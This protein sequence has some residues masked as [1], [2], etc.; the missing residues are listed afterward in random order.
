MAKDKPYWYKKALP[1]LHRIDATA[2]IAGVFLTMPFD[3]PTNY[4]PLSA[5]QIITYLQDIPALRDRLG[6]TPADWTLKEV[7]DGYLNLVYLVDGPNGSVCTKQSLPHVRVD[8]NWPLPLDRTYCEKLYFETVAPF[9]NGATPALYHYDEELSLLVMEKLAP[10]EVLRGNLIAG[11]RIANVG[12]AVGEYVARATYFTSDLYQRSEFKIDSIAKFQRNHVLHRI[13]IELVYQDPY[14][15]LDRNH[16]TTPQ[17]DAFAQ[18]FRTNGRLRAAAG[19]LARKFLASPQALVHNDLHV[20]AVMATDTDLRVIDPEFAVFGPIG[21]DSGIF[22]G[23]LLIAYFS[24]AGYADETDDRTDLQSWILEQIA[25]FWRT[26]RATFLDL[27]RTQPGGDAYIDVQFAD[28]IGREVLE[29]ERQDFLDEL[30]ADT[31]AFAAAAIIRSIVGYSHF[32]EMESIPDP[33]RK[34]A[35]EAGALSLARTIL[36]HPERFRGIG[37]LLAAAPGFQRRPAAP[38]TVLEP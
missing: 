16:W 19:R 22:I 29:Q 21:V 5:D 8:E 9:V 35:S 17:L 27:W 15:A 20:G 4:R 25:D 10:H 38:D 3:T 11:K 36:L 28:V 23:H 6:G 13:M 18:D 1:A 14:I 7:S 26:F 32:P 37:D 24:Q 34:A 31:L 2:S 30:F 33:D 12:K